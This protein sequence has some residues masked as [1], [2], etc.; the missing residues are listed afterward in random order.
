[1]G[2]RAEPEWSCSQ[3]HHERLLQTRLL[4]GRNSFQRLF[5]P[6]A[7]VCP[8]LRVRVPVAQVGLLPARL[9][10][11]PAYFSVV[12]VIVRHEAVRSVN[13]PRAGADDIRNQNVAGPGPVTN[14]HPTRFARRSPERFFEKQNISGFFY[15]NSVHVINFS[16]IVDIV[17]ATKTPAIQAMQQA[18]HRRSSEVHQRPRRHRGS[19][20]ECRRTRSRRPDEQPRG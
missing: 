6:L 19:L 2:P 20:L 3:N 17:P 7:Q 16:G 14:E 15:P 11:M 1:M 12:E 10:V 4:E 5:V 18:F 13:G 9:P 8:R